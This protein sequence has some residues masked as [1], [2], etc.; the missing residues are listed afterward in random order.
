MLDIYCY[1]LEIYA[2][3][4][5]QMV[6]VEFMTSQAL[7]PYSTQKEFKY[8]DIMVTHVFSEVV[9]GLNRKSVGLL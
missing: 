4:S 8:R 3:F 2:Y 1:M 5:P 9:S 7:F 6:S